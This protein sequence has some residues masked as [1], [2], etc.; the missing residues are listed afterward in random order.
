MWLGMALRTASYQKDMYVKEIELRA[1]NVII[2]SRLNG[3][4]NWR[5]IYDYLASTQIFTLILNKDIHVSSEIYA[6]A[7]MA[8]IWIC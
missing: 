5:D 4:H 7:A 6:E 2:H 3:Q 8:S 1:P